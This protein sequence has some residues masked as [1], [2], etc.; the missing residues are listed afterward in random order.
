MDVIFGS[1]T[2]SE[3]REILA[4][5]RKEIGLSV[6]LN[7]DVSKGPRDFQKTTTIKEMLRHAI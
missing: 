2:A 4:E 1:A 7:A 3:D 5:I 6:L